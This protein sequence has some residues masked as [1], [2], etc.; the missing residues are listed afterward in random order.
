VVPLVLETMDHRAEPSFPEVAEREYYSRLRPLAEA[1]ASNAPVR[2]VAV[3]GNQPIGESADRAA[4][5]DSADL[6]FRVNG[7]R[8][9]DAESGPRVGTKTDIVIFN[10][11]VR[12]TPW[13]F[14]NYAHRLYLLI[15]PGRLLWENERVP[16]FWPADLGFV[17]VPNREVILPLNDMIGLDARVD[18]L[19]ATTGTTMLWIAAQLFPDVR[20]DVTGLSFI[21]DP[22]QASWNHAYGDPSPVGPEHRIGNEADLVRSWITEGRITF[23]R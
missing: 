5:I 16:G 13:F 1:Y 4:L 8:L 20:I 15:E 7:F 3:V 23:H 19:W 11:G 6:V 18:G 12:A 2:T 17:T 10:R 22:Y 21:D 14:A 9:D